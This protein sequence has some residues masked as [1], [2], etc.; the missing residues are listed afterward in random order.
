MARVATRISLPTELSDGARLCPQDQ[1]Q[2]AEG[3]KRLKISC[4]ADLLVA[5]RQHLRLISLCGT[6][7]CS[8]RDAVAAF[9]PALAQPEDKW[10]YARPHPGLLPRG[11]GE[12]FA[13]SMEYLRR[14]WSDGLRAISMRTLAVPSP[15]GEGQGE[16]GCCANPTPSA[17]MNLGNGFPGWARVAHPARIP[18]RT[19][20][21][22]P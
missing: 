13:V 8:Y 17:L 5:V 2:R 10:I 1:S 6:Q 21:V 20:L 11:E 4:G 19:A 12:S 16:G 15:W 3:R 7:P 22:A 9:S 18:A 14:D